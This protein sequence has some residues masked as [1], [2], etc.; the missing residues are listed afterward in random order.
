MSKV[1]SDYGNVISVMIQSRHYSLKMKIFSLVLVVF[2][3]AVSLTSWRFISS[4][5]N[6]SHID[7][8]KS[9]HTTYLQQANTAN[10]LSINGNFSK[11]ANSWI[12]Y[13]AQTT[14]RS[15]KGE[16]YV[17]AAANYLSEH[18][19]AS[20]FQMCKK[21]EL[22]DGVTYGEAQEAAA[23]AQGLGDNTV[24]IGYYQKAIQLIPRSMYGPETQKK[25]FELDI[26]E[27]QSKS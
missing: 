21:A 26:Q 14:N 24:A 7:L 1:P 15:Q 5:E 13:A 18:Q 6:I 3:G 25:I 22:I 4:Q 27:L 10:N 8:P 23:A 11:A 20:A 12:S 2:V 9:N 19:Y 17:N 16:A